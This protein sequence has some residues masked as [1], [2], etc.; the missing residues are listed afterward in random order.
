[1]LFEGVNFIPDAIKPMGKDDFIE[2]HKDVL[3]QDRD[4][5]DREK[6]LSDVYDTIVKD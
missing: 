5:E 2:A 1:M 6:M 4:E 3:W